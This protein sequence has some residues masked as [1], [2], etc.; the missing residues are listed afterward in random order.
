MVVLGF[1]GWC[2]LLKRRERR[3]LG[4]GR[5]EMMK[6]GGRETWKDRWTD[7]K[8][9]SSWKDGTSCGGYELLS[10]CAAKG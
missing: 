1:E 5:C 9:M 2:V 6:E 7:R 3:G 8:E 10:S 4:R